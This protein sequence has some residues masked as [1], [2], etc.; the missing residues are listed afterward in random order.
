MATLTAPIK[1]TVDMLLHN[2]ELLT[3]TILKGLKLESARNVIA[4]AVQ[5]SIEKGTFPVDKLLDSPGTLR[6]L[7][8]H[9]VSKPSYLQGLSNAVRN[10]DLN[11]DTFDFAKAFARKFFPQVSFSQTGEDLI[12]DF[13]FRQ[14][15][16]A[17]PTYIDIGAY[18]PFELNNTALFYING[19]TGICIEP[20]PDLFKLFPYYRPQDINL[21]VG[22]HQQ[23][24]VLDYYVMEYDTLNTFS[25]AIAEDYAQNS[26]HKIK[27][28]LQIPVTT[29]SSVLQEH[30]GGKFPDYMSLDTEGV[31]QVI[32]E[33]IDYTDNYP[34]VICVETITYSTV[35]RGIKEQEIID[36]LKGKGYLVFAD[37]YI[38][39]ILVRKDL[40]IR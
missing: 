39:T 16:I 1:K 13:I 30:F 22:I 5:K 31:D 28:T 38:N 36:F 9:I 6:I 40:W 7:A 21:N 19:S 20:N 29:L 8:E 33:S 27:D 32:L 3:S 17:K 15:G 25:K 12:V 35:G 2:T 14:L 24:G 4:T 37:T 34:K 10:V 26:H 11:R 18:H 23:A